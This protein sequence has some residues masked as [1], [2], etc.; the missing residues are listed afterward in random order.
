MARVHVQPDPVLAAEA[1]RSR[2]GRRRG[3]C[4]SRMRGRRARAAGRPPRSARAL[5]EPLGPIRSSRRPRAR[6]PRPRR[7]RGSPPRAGPSSARTGVRAGR[8]QPGSRSP[9]VRGHV[10]A[11]GEQRGEVRER[12]AAGQDAGRAGVEAHLVEHPAHDLALDRRPGGAHLVDR[13]RVVRG[14]VDQVGDG[15]AGRRDRHPGGPSSRGGAGA[16]WRRGSAAAS[17]QRGGVHARR[18]D[19]ARRARGRRRGRR[20][21]AGRSPARA[22]ARASATCSASSPTAVWRPR[23]S[24]PSLSKYAPVRRGIW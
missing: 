12:P 14:P 20:D 21:R 6:A 1:D 16:P 15:G 4:W 23:R 17:L 24:R 3:R 22:S 9:G 2:A 8:G 13:H 7:A 18:P 11:R 19:P 5:V 10:G